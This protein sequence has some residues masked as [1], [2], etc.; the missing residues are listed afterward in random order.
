MPTAEQQP[1]LRDIR[2]LLV[3][4]NEADALLVTTELRRSGYRVSAERVQT[5]QALAAA[6]AVGGWDLVIS[7]YA[8]PGFDALGALAIFTQSGID[9]PFIVVS[10]TID[11]DSA[12]SA[13]RSGAHDF[14]VK[15]KLARLGPA[16]DR[17]LREAL[18]RADRRK[19]EEQLMV[20]DRMASV[21]ML[22]AGLAHEINNPLAAVLANIHSVRD[23]LLRMQPQSPLLA[24]LTEATDDAYVA[25]ERVRQIVRDVKIFSRAG[26][27]R[28][29]PVNV[30][31][32][33][34]STARMIWNDMRHRARLIKQYG[35]VAA[36]LGT[37]ARLGQLFLNLLV[38][39]CDALPPGHA[40]RNEITL[41]TRMGAGRVIIE[42]TD[43]GSGISPEIRER[44]FTPF[45]TTKAAGRGTGLGLSI[46]R[47]IV[48]EMEGEISVDSEPGR[49]STFRVSLPP[50][51]GLPSPKESSTGL[52]ALLSRRA[53]VL[54]VDDEVM[55][56]TAIRRILS[57]SHDVSVTFKAREALSR[58]QSGERFDVLLCDV[59]MPDMTG[60]DLHAALER[61]DGDQARRMLFMTGGTFTAQAAAFLDERRDR[62]IEKPFDKPA[63][64]AAI[65]SMLSTIEAVG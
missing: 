42:V 10:G 6:L 44:L 11:E 58:L 43:T 63:L 53:R 30:E 50:T 29:V 17:E 36:V 24:D 37:E 33:L 8:L 26:E 1:T 14:I 57:Q 31:R 35:G 16:V 9:I 7:D 41:A 47:R 5:A 18:L 21:G 46:C 19:M 39:A 52:P 59:S 60:I 40:G 12:V 64:V 55:I 45:F 62:V 15:N 2:V 32:V 25:A 20:S 28:Q 54:V 38:N 4:D 65:T 51:A 56:T 49:G 48:D 13:L 61:V 34:D 27:D 23:G 3:E 22:A